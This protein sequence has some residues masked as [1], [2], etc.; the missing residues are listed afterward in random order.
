V[1][2]VRCRI[3]KNVRLKNVIVMGNDYYPTKAEDHENHG[4]P[5]MGIG[6]NSVIEET[7]IDKNC[8]IGKNVVIRNVNKVQLTPEQPF[9]MIRDGVVCICKHTVLPDN[10]SLEKA[11]P[12]CVTR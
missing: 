9:G 12:M 11:S 6:D 7:I 3:G 1:I 4:T 2:G 8:K 10:W 5:V